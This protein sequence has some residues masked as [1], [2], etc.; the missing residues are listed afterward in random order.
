MANSDGQVRIIIDTNAQAAS[1]AL[2]MV[3]KSFNKTAKTVK[4]TTTVYNAYEQGINSNIEALREMALAG[5]QN[6]KEFQKLAEKTREY[7]KALDEA[8]NSVNSAIGVTAQQENAMSKLATVAKNLGL[9]YIGLQS[10]RFFINYSKE[11]VQAIRTEEIAVKQLNQTLMNAGVYT[12]QYSSEIQKL[13]NEIQEY[14]N[15]GNEA[16]LRAVALG[17][18]YAGNTK[19]TKE[20]TKAVVDFASATGMD[21][22]QAFNLV[23]KSIG[24]STNALGR[25]GI[26]LKQGMTE[27]EKMIAIQTQ[28]EARYKGSASEMRNSSIQ[29]QNALG[30]LSKAFGRVLNPT[31]EKTEQK[32]KTSVYRL[33]DWI[34]S[35]RVLYSD[36]N[37][38]DLEESQLKYKQTLTLLNR[39]DDKRKAQGFLSGPE[40]GKYYQAVKDLMQV[41]AHMDSIYKKQRELAK[42][43]KT[44]G[45][46]RIND[47]FGVSSVPG[48][49]ASTSASAEKI[50]D[51]FEKAQEKAQEAEKA[52]KLA[53]YK[54]GEG[55][56]QVDIA[57]KKWEDT[58]KAVDDVQK[59]YEKLTASGKTPFEQLNFN[60]QEAQKKL[61]NLASADVVDLEKIRQAQTELQQWQ[62]RIDT[63]NSYLQVPK[64]KL[65]ELNI[66]IQETERLL[67]DLYFTKG[68][69]SDE[70]IKAKNELAAYQVE[71]KNFNTAIT[72]RVGLDWDN[73]SKSI[74]SNLSSAILTPLQ[75]GESAFNRL[76]T[77][78]LNAVQLVGQEI[79]K[80]LLEQI[81]LEKTLTAIRAAGKAVGSF[82]GLTFADGGVFKNGNVIP[83][84]RGGVVN[85]PTVF[86]MAN[87]GTGLMGEAGA[88]AVMPLKRMSNGKLG[89]EADTSKNG[90]VVNIYNYSGASVE[91]RK[92]DDNSVDVFIRRVNDALSNERTQ[93]GFR[94][95]YSRENNKGVQAV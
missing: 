92:R 37:K 66:K 59:A 21:L 39:L 77:I 36:I 88:E 28:L 22:E 40:Q 61:Q 73:V 33:R 54:Y 5:G 46:L 51:A 34:D 17:Q 3:E 49:G 52:F 68:V 44:T 82:F 12:A 55:S 7:K 91:T 32:L 86:P 13:A 31:I 60:L 30:E 57:R 38:L 80:N 70:F 83:F 42:Q 56:Q 64:T 26:E 41:E 84:A 11:A 14:S 29:L 1:K 45:N 78:G 81:T 62:S 43:S 19:I 27:A 94:S 23:G 63:V 48:G 90:Q 6:S 75:E 20:L 93:S 15:Y 72:S 9:A 58:K 50:K 65:E 4:D 89:V 69:N 47:D 35:V 67:Q 53:L 85:Q 76:A 10:I 25:Y 79:I 16:V 74:K 18:A 24:S 87:G 8:N 95:A 71:A 2:D